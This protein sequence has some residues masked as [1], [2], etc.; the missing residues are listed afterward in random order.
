VQLLEILL[1]PRVGQ[2]GEDLGRERVGGR[3]ELA[4][5]REP[6]EHMFGILARGS[7]TATNEPL[8][9]CGIR[10]LESSA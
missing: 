9:T 10:R 3:T 6:L 5:R 8:G 7:D 4:H 1:D 2:L